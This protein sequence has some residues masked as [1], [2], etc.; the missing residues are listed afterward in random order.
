MRCVEAKAAGWCETHQRRLDDCSAIFSE[1]ERNKALLEKI[2]LL[3]KQLAARKK[4][5]AVE[6][7]IPDEKTEEKN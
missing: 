6:E 5:K 4:S 7:E 2:T 1:S 3:E